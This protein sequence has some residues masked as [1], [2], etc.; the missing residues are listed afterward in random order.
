MD[1][2]FQIFPVGFVRKEGKSDRI[3]IRSEFAEALLGLEPY[4]H[5]ILCVW[6]H[7]S[8]TP[9]KRKTLQVHPM[10]NRSIPLTGV[11]GTRSPVRPNPIALYVA[12]IR[13]IRDSIIHIDPISA[14][15]NTPVIDIKPYIHRV[16]AV[17][18]AVVPDWVFMNRPMQER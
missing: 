10:G 6:F 13:S 17:P 15:D 11:F 18:D 3:E 5:L 2:T 16:D 9:D 12:R 1:N 4:S 8:D 14:F 7:A